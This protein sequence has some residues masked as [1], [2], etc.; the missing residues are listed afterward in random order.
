[1]YVGSTTDVCKRWASTK[2][3]CLD[4]D[5][6]NTGLYKHFKTGCP[7]GSG[8]GDLKH[9]RWTLI[10][11]METTVDKL[12]VANHEGGARC[13]CSECEKLKLIEDK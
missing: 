9:L 5:S 1:M 11:S 3:A 6:N 12:R 8:G 7:A 13:R 10:D 4:C 2:K